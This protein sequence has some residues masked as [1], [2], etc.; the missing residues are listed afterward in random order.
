M[1]PKRQCPCGGYWLPESIG[2]TV[3]YRPAG[4]RREYKVQCEWCGNCTTIVREPSFPAL[5]LGRPRKPG[6]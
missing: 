1:N 3:L 2:G 5:P 6:T 4:K